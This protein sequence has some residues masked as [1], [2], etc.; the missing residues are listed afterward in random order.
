MLIFWHTFRSKKSCWFFGTLCILYFTYRGGFA[1]RIGTVQ[2]TKCAK[3]STWFF[4][5]KSVPKNQHKLHVI[6]NYI[7][8]LWVEEQIM[9]TPITCGLGR[10]L[11]SPRVF[12][13]NCDAPRGEARQRGGS[14]SKVWDSR[15]HPECSRNDHV[16]QKLQFWKPKFFQDASKSSPTPPKID[17]KGLLEPMLGQ[18]FKKMWFGTSNK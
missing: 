17:P 15:G 2:N 1:P 8:K 18:C 13:K 14:C 12:R 9:S 6:N 3:K 7:C 11:L 10:L 5:S 4:G 16:T